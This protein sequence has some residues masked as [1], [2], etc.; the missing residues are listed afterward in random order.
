GKDFVRRANMQRWV[1]IFV[2]GVLVG[3]V[4][5]SLILPVPAA[6]QEEKTEEI[7]RKAK[8]KVAP[9]YPDI[10]RRMSIAGTVR[11]AIVVA[12]NGSVKSS[13]AVGGHPVLVNAAM[14]AVKQ[15]KFEPAATESTGIVEFKFQPLN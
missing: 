5:T 7:S 1:A 13:K 11:L 6:A 12:P 3:T 4:A 14:D 15:W 8:T 10:A 9:I 2:L